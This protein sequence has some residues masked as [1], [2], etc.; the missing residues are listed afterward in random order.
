MFLPV[1]S[2]QILQTYKTDE[3]MEMMLKNMDFYVTPVLNID[4]YIYSWED[5]SVSACIW[6]MFIKLLE[7]LKPQMNR[8]WEAH[9]LLPEWLLNQNK[10]QFNHW[11]KLF[12]MLHMFHEEKYLIY[13]E[14]RCGDDT[15]R[16]PIYGGFSSYRNVKWPLNALL[17]LVRTDWMF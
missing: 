7:A 12:L 14:M 2:N 4:G 6:W 13:S 16:A 15:D 5:D 11:G 8:I 3:K 17:S 1:L 10:L 9:W